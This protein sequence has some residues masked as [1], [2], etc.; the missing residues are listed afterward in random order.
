M[1]FEPCKLGVWNV[2]V[3]LLH[4]HSWLY[5]VWSLLDLVNVLVRAKHSG[6]QNERLR[7]ASHSNGW[8]WKLGTLSLCVRSVLHLFA[9]PCVWNIMLPLCAIDRAN[10]LFFVHK[11]GCPSHLVKRWRSWCFCPRSSDAFP[12][13]HLSMIVESNIFWWHNTWKNQW[14]KILFEYVT[15][16]VSF[17]VKVFLTTCCVLA[18]CCCLLPF[19]HDT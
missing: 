12:T 11:V 16:R 1:K 19:N 8:N 4:L 5:C 18:M 14:T 9:L 10:W 2:C 7:L 17:I 13:W 3:I 6:A 15:L